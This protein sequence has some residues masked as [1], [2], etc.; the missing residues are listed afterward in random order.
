[1][2]LGL[3]M[4]NTILDFDFATIPLK[5]DYVGIYTDVNKWRH[6]LWRVTLYWP[7]GYHSFD[8]RCGMA[9][10]T[11]AIPI[12]PSNKSIMYS[13]LMDSRAVDESFIDWCGNYGYSDDSITAFNLY[14]D[15]CKTAVILRKIFNS[16]DLAA[17]RVA[18]DDY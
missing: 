1:M 7:N 15:C 4:E 8:Y 17:M 14:R 2:G 5:V 10:Q 11:K 3:K 12:K 6:H 18:L 13:L 16:D 9:H